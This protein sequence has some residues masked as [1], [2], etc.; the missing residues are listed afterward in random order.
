MVR[1]PDPHPL[2]GTRMAGSG[3]RESDHRAVI[4]EKPAVLRIAVDR[5]AEEVVTLLLI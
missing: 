2:E 1:H 4:I 5:A 3:L